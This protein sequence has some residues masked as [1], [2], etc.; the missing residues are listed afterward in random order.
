[1]LKCGLLQLCHI[2]ATR[3]Q[4]CLLRILQPS[5]KTL[6]NLVELRRIGVWVVLSKTV[7]ITCDYN[8]VLFVCL[9]IQ[10]K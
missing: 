6:F 7:I 5:L 1:M 10:T 3:Q 2:I 9:E 4:I 8:K